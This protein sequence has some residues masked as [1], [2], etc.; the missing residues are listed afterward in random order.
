[1]AQTDPIATSP[2]SK[3]GEEHDRQ[4]RT[5]AGESRSAGI[6]E[7]IEVPSGHMRISNFT[8]ANASARSPKGA[9]SGIP[10]TS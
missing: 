10:S 6:V 1:V 7:S 3:D 4:R 2:A 9:L 8:Q 5:Q